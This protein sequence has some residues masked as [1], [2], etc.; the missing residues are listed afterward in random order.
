MGT[1]MRWRRA[2]CVVILATAVAGCGGGSHAS[3]V[4][5]RVVTTVKQTTARTRSFAQLVQ[6]VRSG[7]IRI[8]AQDCGGAGDIGTGILVSPRLVATVDHVVAGAQTIALKR[9]GVILGYGKVMGEDPARDVALVRSSRPITGHIFELSTRQP[10]LG[11]AVATLGFPLGLPLTVTRGS[12]S[13]LHRAI[14]IEAIVRQNM[15]QTDAAVNPGNSGGPLVSA[16]NGEVLGLVDLGT[17]EANGLAFAVSS[18]VASPL[19]QAWEAAP[20]PIAAS[21]CAGAGSGGSTPTVAAASFAGH[22]FSVDYPS[23]WRIASDE[24]D[25]GSYND[26][27]IDNPSNTLDLIRV[28]ISP[29]S[30]STLRSSEKIEASLASQPGYQRIAWRSTTIDGQRGLYWEFLV[31]EN[32]LLLH[33]VDV[34]STS[35]SGNGVAILTQSPAGDWSQYAA[36]FTSVRE[37]LNAY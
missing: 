12:V 29:G 19:L 21:G 15:I 8:E 10:R 27:V 30:P 23:G 13:G 32:G 22:E 2:S 26:T 18:R 5:Q 11:D 3:T 1:P 17:N 28:D 4:T 20:Q 25:L 34:F 33:K 7:V 35:P 16:D 24:R 9:G 36:T 6:S 31:E 37:T 14:P